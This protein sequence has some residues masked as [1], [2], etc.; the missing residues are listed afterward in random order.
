MKLK[1]GT[2]EMPRTLSAICSNVLVLQPLEMLKCFVEVSWQC[3]DN[4]SK[5][6][7]ALVLT[8]I[9]PELCI[10]GIFNLL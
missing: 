2:S 4:Q 8:F 6:Q 1:T 7:N 5:S 9:F 3:E 10:G